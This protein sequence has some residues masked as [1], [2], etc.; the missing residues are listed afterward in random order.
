M[1]KVITITNQKGGVAKTTTNIALAKLLA[2]MNKKILLIDC[3]HQGNLSQSFNSYHKTQYTITDV[4]KDRRAK[5]NIKKYIHHAEENIDIIS[6]DEDFTFVSNDIILDSSRIQQYIL[7]NALSMIKQEYDFIFIDNAPSYNNITINAL[8]C[9]DYVL[10]PMEADRYSDRGFTEL[11]KRIRE[12]QSDLNPDLEL[13]GTY[14]TKINTRLVEFQ[15]FYT[16]Y[17]EDLQEFFIPVAIRKCEKRHSFSS[18]NNTIS[19]VRDYKYFLSFLGILNKEDQE[20]LDQEVK[21]LLIEEL[22]KYYNGNLNKTFIVDYIE[23][24]LE[25]K[26]LK[27][28][29]KQ[30]E[31]VIR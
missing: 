14:F 11:L 23:Y 7:K 5:E 18:Q 21:E 1:G 2:S 24:L 31:K 30:I 12:I 13:L 6:A 15:Q 29:I 26:G 19:I 9:S 16:T 22:K 28:E 17:Q 25:L 10:V 8:V 4:F 27:E 20:K 3:D